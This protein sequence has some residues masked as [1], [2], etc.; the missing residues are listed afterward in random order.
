MDENEKLVGQTSIAR[1]RRQRI[2]KLAAEI[3]R[4]KWLFAFSLFWL[5][6]CLVVSLYLII[7]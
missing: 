6:V 1:A 4:D 3:E 7:A 2:A 5:A